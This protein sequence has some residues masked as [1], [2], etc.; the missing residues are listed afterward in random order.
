M[1]KL[2]RLTVE[3]ARTGLTD[4][5]GFF[6]A[7][8]AIRKDGVIVGS[9]NGSA[10]KPTLSIHAEARV[11]KKAGF[12]ATL[13]V[14]RVRRDGTPTIAM[15]CDGCMRLIRAKRVERVYWTV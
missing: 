3:L 5:K 6:L 2:L 9:R 1:N 8:I 15:P 10:E 12:G 14:A 7:A 13:Y 4:D 11:L